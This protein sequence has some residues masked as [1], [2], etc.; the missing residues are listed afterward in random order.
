MCLDSTKAISKATWMASY[1]TL[2]CDLPVAPIW[3]PI[4][5]AKKVQKSILLIFFKIGTDMTRTEAQ[6]FTVYGN[7]LGYITKI[8]PNIMENPQFEIGVELYGIYE[9]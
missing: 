3:W 1:L 2:I 7:A 4:V 5:A 6:A 8:I 9:E